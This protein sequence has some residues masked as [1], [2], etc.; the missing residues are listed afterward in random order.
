M[1]APASP[2]V[3]LAAFTPRMAGYFTGRERFALTL[4]GAVLRSRITVPY[5]QSGAGKSSILGAAL[6]QVL[7]ATLRRA[8]EATQR[9]PFR[10]LNFRRWH[11]GFEKRLYRAAAAKLAAPGDSGLAAGVGAWGRQQKS[12]VILV[13]DQFEEF[14]LYHPKP[15]ET[16]FVRDLATVVANPDIEARVLLSL[17]EDSLASLDAL[18]AVIPGILASPVQLRPLDRTAA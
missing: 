17:R 12:P 15:T 6:P 14:L 8:A 5:G 7:Q 10:L 13:L 4:A 1:S 9:A 16:T 11:R 3:G 18:R 2:F